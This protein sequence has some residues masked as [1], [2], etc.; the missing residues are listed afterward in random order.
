MKDKNQ[1]VE[2]HLEAERN[3]NKR[4]EADL[5]AAEQNRLKKIA[6]IERQKREEEGNRKNSASH[7]ISQEELTMQQQNAQLKQ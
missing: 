4:I 2:E 7:I 1:A 3:K 5:Q 6:E